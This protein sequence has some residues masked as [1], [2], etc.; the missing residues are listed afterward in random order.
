MITGIHPYADKFPMLP[1][2]ELQELS[3]SIRSNGQRNPI[4]TTP[5]GLIIDG[6]NRNKACEMAGVEPLTEVYEGDDIAEY[7]IDCNVTRRNMSTGA[8]AMSTA[9]VLAADGR[10]E[11]GRW[12]RGSVGDISEVGNNDGWRKRLAEAGVVI[13]FKPDLV[14]LVVTGQATLNDAFGQAEKIRT[15]AERDKI[16]AREQA[17]REKDEAKAEAEANARIVADLTQANSPHL[18]LIENNQMSP[19]AA[20][21]AHL[22]DTEKQ[23]KHDAEMAR[24]WRDTCMHIAEAV[25]TFRGGS[26]YGEMF[27]REFYP[28]ESEYVPEGM[29]ITRAALEEATAFLSTIKEGVAR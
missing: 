7:V 5:D 27:L 3:D 26:G 9:L 18:A 29:Q 22:A 11:N 21:A 4:I 8:R 6:R 24:G 12:K 25:R 20:W 16:M 10:R 1:E 15:S 17:R 13:D 28:H 2:S 23:R 19:K 14:E